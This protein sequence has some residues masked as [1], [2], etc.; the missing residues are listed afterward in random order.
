[1]IAAWQWQDEVRLPTTIRQNQRSTSAPN[2]LIFPGHRLVGLGFVRICCVNRYACGCLLLAQ[3]A[4]RINVGQEFLHKRLHT[5]TMEAIAAAFRQCPQ[6]AIGQPCPLL[7]TG[8]VGG[9]E[10]APAASS[11]LP[12]ALTLF[13]LPT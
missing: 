10:V 3:L 13:V 6:G 11:F 2:R 9:N 7:A 12:E 1:M 4:G 8:N 5:L